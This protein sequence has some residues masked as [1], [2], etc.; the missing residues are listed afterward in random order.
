MGTDRAATVFHRS[1]DNTLNK[2]AEAE[3]MGV[4]CASGTRLA[5]TGAERR[6]ESPSSLP[7][8]QNPQSG[9]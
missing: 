8:K 7:G 5:R 9:F 4:L 1:H 3:G 6:A 2:C